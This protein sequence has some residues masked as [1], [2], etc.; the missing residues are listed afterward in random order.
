VING[1]S[2]SWK[3]SREGSLRNRCSVKLQELM[4]GVA[5]GT[6]GVRTRVALLHQ[7][8]SEETL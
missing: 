7:A 3:F 5:I 1:A 6:D 2:I 4:E 8:L